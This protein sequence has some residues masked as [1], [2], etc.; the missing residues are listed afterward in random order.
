MADKTVK[1]TPWSAINVSFETPDGV[2][3]T[4]AIDYLGPDGEVKLP[5]NWELVYSEDDY[6]EQLAERL[7][8]EVKGPVTLEDGEAVKSIIKDMVETYKTE[9]AFQNWVHNLKVGDKVTWND[10]DTDCEEPQ[11]TFEIGCIEW[12]NRAEGMLFLSDKEH[13]FELEC[14]SHE[15]SKPVEGD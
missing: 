14:F 8:F 2:D 1:T 3:C 12:I 4:F 6:N 10:P 15:L 13:S 7:W 9:N 11:K 5:K